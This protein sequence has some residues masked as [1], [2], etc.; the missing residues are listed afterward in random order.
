VER[1]ARE[2]VPDVTHA[3][4]GGAGGNAAPRSTAPG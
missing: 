1:F 3:I 4:T 2:I